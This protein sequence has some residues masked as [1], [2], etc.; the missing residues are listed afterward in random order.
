MPTHCFQGRKSFFFSFLL[1]T[2]GYVFIDLETE[3]GRV[4]ERERKH[5]LV[6]PLLRP[7][8]GSNPQSFSVQD[9]A[10]DNRATRPRLCVFYL[11]LSNRTRLQ[12]DFQLFG[13]LRTHFIMWIQD[14]LPIICCWP[15]VASLFKLEFP[16]ELLPQIT[17]Y[18]GGRF[19]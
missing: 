6:V 12:G 3:K 1:L 13:F 18:M 5:L 8:Q 7:D 17:A 2:Q 19:L 10:L 16:T 4:S 14:Y 9:D 15:T 11:S